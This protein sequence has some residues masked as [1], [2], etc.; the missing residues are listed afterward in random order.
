[1]SVN[2]NK[3]RLK[4]E[5]KYLKEKVEE[6]EKVRELRRGS[7]SWKNLRTLKKLKLNIKDKLAQLER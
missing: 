1:M 7:N 4:R 5:F 2:P 3:E 6:A